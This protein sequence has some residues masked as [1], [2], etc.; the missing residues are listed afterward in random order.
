[1]FS[2]YLPSFKMHSDGLTVGSYSCRLSNV[3][4]NLKDMG[5]GAKI[6]LAASIPA[7]VGGTKVNSNTYYQS[8][9]HPNVEYK[10]EIF[11]PNTANDF[12][13]LINNILKCGKRMLPN[14]TEGYFPSGV[15]QV[16]GYLGDGGI[17]LRQ[18]GYDYDNKNETQCMM[19]FMDQAWGSDSDDVAKHIGIGIAASVGLCVAVYVVSEIIKCCRSNHSDLQQSL[20]NQNNYS[21]NNNNN[22]FQPAQPTAVVQQQLTPVVEEE[23]R[24]EDVCKI[25]IPSL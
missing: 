17:V 19:D 10:L 18:N 22:F 21:T 9:G 24:S 16:G 12:Q 5:R 13:A 15:Y 23:P 3:S 8:I 1:M 6:L 14:T 4:T 20:L 7:I 25:T 11:D 2:N